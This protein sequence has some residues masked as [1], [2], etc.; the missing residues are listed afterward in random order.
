MSHQSKFVADSPGHIK[1]KPSLG[2]RNFDKANWWMR[3]GSSNFEILANPMCSTHPNEETTDTAAE[4]STN[5][6]FRSRNIRIPIQP[7]MRGARI[8]RF[9][10]LTKA[11]IWRLFLECACEITDNATNVNAICVNG[12][13]VNLSRG[14]GGDRSFFVHEPDSFGY[15]KVIAHICF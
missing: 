8:N 5:H 15:Y 13:A 10:H 12:T 11:P 6:F 2:A 7:G 14:V 1:F 4:I 3:I 9:M